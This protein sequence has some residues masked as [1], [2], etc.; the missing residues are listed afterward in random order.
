MKEM[1][2]YGSWILYLSFFGFLCL[3][4]TSKKEDKNKTQTDK[5]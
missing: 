3:F 2:F 4:C 1:L 5:H